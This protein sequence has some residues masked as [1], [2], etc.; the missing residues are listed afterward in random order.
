MLLREP[1]EVPPVPCRL[2]LMASAVWL[3]WG[4][5]DGKVL[6]VLAIAWLIQHRGRALPTPLPS[7]LL[8]S[9][10]PCLSA[11]AQRGSQPGKTQRARQVMEQ[12]ADDRH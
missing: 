11:S 9:I 5:P 1:L 3:Y 4:Q 10:M 7:C 6:A 2:S 12:G 8:G